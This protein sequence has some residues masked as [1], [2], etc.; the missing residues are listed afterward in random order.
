[1]NIRVVTDRAII[2]Q[3]L[4]GLGHSAHQVGAA[5]GLV[6]VV[7]DLLVIDGALFPAQELAGKKLMTSAIY[8]SVGKGEPQ[9]TA[10]MRVLDVSKM[11]AEDIAAAINDELNKIVTIKVS[12]NTAVFFGLAHEAGTTMMV[13]EIANMI[14]ANIQASVLVMSLTETP[15][16]E[17]E[18]FDANVRDVITLLPRMSMGVLTP[19]EL[20]ASVVKANGINYIHGIHSLTN[21]PDYSIEDVAE[22]IK[23]AS[24]SFD[25]VLID[26]GADIN[27]MSVAAML[28]GYVVYLVT[29]PQNKGL[30]RFEQFRAEIMPKVNLSP[31]KMRIILNKVGAADSVSAII[32]QYGGIQEIGAVPF[33]SHDL[34]IRS[35]LEARPLSRFEGTN[36]Y[37]GAVL[38]LGRE[39]MK[40][41]G[42][43]IEA[44]VRASKGGLFR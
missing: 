22:L 7:E 3:K 1:M 33:V 35:E 4:N 39:T 44:L 5:A 25:Y 40:P 14:M 34:A 43:K 31:V 20:T 26:A 2:V 13:Q 9:K 16:L 8:L 21:I 17:Y 19:E 29:T 37:K 42:I 6:N 36:K 41:L 28:S 11:P 38:A 18:T 15:G 27:R 12:H 30:A 23:T 32:R 10:K 24:A